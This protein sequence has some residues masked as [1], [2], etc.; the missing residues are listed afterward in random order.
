MDTSIIFV[1]VFGI[2]VI[3]AIALAKY[4]QMQEGKEEKQ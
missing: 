4:I 3:G 1:I 2:A